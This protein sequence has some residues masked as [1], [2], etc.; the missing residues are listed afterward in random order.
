MS[1]YNNGSNNDWCTSDGVEISHGKWYGKGP[2]NEKPPETIHEAC[3]KLKGVI[4]RIKS[5][6]NKYDGTVKNKVFS[7]EK[8]RNR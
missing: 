2:G 4:E 5:I 7:R 3:D 1:P 8:S 6:E